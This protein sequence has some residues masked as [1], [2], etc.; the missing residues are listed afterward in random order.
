MTKT[1]I[2]GVTVD[3]RLD[4]AENAPA[5]VLIHSLGT[6]LSAWDDVVPRLADDFR[7]LRYSIRGHG[8][9]GA[10]PGPYSL[11]LLAGDL[12]ALLDHAGLARVHVVGLSIGGMIAQAFAL[13]HPDRL[14]RLALC[15]TFA[16]LPDTAR[17][18]WDE[19]IAA[20]RAGGMKSQVESALARW[21]TPGFLDAHPAVRTRVT[22]M[23][24]DATADG[25]IGCCAAIRDLDL[26][27]RL[28]A[29]RAPTLVVAGAEDPAA[30]PDVAR[31]IAAA[32]PGAGLAV[33]EG[34]SHQIAIEQ[35]EALGDIL[36][37]FLS[38]S[39]G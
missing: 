18:A 34:A 13:E 22:E 3:W 20:V 8:A 10:T 24:R 12:A 35:P 21:F 4:G 17:P 9:S 27:P 30:T 14:D 19:R 33:V 28:H 36:W 7:V 29:V 2:N 25:Y 11:S 26:L 32:I 38:G 15:A 37:P 23:I 1:T 5:V 6:E 16:T 39:A 31:T